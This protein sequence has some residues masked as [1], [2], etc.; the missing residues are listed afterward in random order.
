ML[1]VDIRSRASY[2]SNT[3]LP[4]LFLTI[5]V[6]HIEARLKE[7][8]LSEL[9]ES[10]GRML[11]HRE[12]YNAALDQSIIIGYWENI[13]VNEVKTPAEVYAA[14]KDEGY[15]IQYRRIPL[16]REREPLASD[17]DA[18]QYCKDE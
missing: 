11:L 7:D 13:S 6:E 3:L 14:L 9:R 2:F 4:F 1:P 5:Q 15:N 17:V 8:I 10:G 16:T 12:E 18:I